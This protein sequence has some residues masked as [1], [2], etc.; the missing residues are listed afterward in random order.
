MR[1][2]TRKAASVLGL[3]FLTAL[4]MSQSNTQSNS[5]QSNKAG[6]LGGA[7]YTQDPAAIIQFLSRTISWHHQLTAEQRLASQPSDLSFLQENRRAADQVV[8]LAIDYAR[9]QAQ[10]QSRQHGSQPAQSSANDSSGQAQRMEQAL[11][12]LNQQIEQT[13]G[14]IQGF[15]EKLSTASEA[16]RNALQSQIAE[17]QSEVSLLQARRDALASM[18]E[19]V[20][21]SSSGG[22]GA[23]LRA[24]IEELAGAVPVALSRGSASNQEEVPS[25][26]A[27]SNVVFEPSGIWGMAA[28]L[29]RLSGKLRTLKSELSA[30]ESLQ[31]EA[32]KLRA[33]LLDYLGNLVR[34]GDQ[35]ASQADISGPAAL[36]Q[37]KQ[38]LDSLTTQFRQTS[39]GLLPLSK[40]NV[41]LGLQQTTIKNWRES[42]R[43]QIRDELRQLL[44]RLGVL[45]VLIA[46]VFGVGEF[47]RRATYRYVHDGRRRYQFLLLRRIVIWAAI[48]LIL[49]L[50]FATQLGSAVTFAGLLTAGIAVALQNVIVSVVGYFF[51]IGKYGLRVGDRVQIAGVTGEVVEIGLVRIHLMELAG[52]G[53][54]QPTGRVVA[55]SNAIVFQPTAGLFKQI[56]GTNFVWHELKLVL[57]ADSDYHLARDRITQAVDSVLATYQENMETQRVLM[58]RNLSSVSGADLK[59]KVRLYYTASGIEVTVRFPVELGKAAE[60]DDHLMRELLTAADREPKLKLV[61]AEMPVAKAGD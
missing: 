55:F 7:V 11:Q 17:T 10:L 46:M 58:E 15:R 45:V 5:T 6:N 31:Q 42:I 14:E 23:G 44:L 52:A 49:I 32:Q 29:I 9:S 24:Q 12:N 28:D 33:P 35:L 57:A 16:R 38:Q 54:S 43:D 21:S 51:L 19:F 8:R 25:Q 3:L 1:V 30:S 37:Q 40:I 13:Q 53:E 47:W 36:A 50:T 26:P 41:L 34:E 39:A 56:P 4:L 18:I 20:N 22:G 48:I 27:S 60:M 59:P 61:S 2:T